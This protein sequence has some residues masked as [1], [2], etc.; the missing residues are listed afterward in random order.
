MRCIEKVI[1]FSVVDTET[2]W[3]MNSFLSLSQQYASPELVP[4]NKVYLEFLF[5]D[6]NN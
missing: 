5:D 1:Y 6:W 2:V 4:Y 3:E